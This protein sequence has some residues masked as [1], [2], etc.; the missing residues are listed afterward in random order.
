MIQ[1]PNLKMVSGFVLRNGAL[2][3]EPPQI[4][5]WVGIIIEKDR[6]NTG[7]PNLIIATCWRELDLTEKARTAKVKELWQIDGSY[8]NFIEQRDKGYYHQHEARFTGIF[9]VLH[10]KGPGTFMVHSGFSHF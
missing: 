4:K 8:G 9:L 2:V 6:K 5:I 1:I 7:E 10:D 3:E